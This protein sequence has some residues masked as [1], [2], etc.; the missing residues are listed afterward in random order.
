M[1]PIYGKAQSKPADRW[2]MWEFVM[3]CACVWVSASPAECLFVLPELCSLLEADIKSA[4]SLVAQK[5]HSSVYHLTA[6]QSTWPNE[7]TVGILAVV[8]LWMQMEWCVRAI[9]SLLKKKLSEGGH[10]CV[11]VFVCLLCHTLLLLQGWVTPL[12]SGFSWLKTF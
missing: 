10:A 12:A 2:C 5:R 3:V 9:S 1:S 6:V 7:I 8:H 4:A 11:C